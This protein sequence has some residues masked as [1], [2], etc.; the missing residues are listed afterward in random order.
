MIKSIISSSLASILLMSSGLVFS[1]DR[2]L[3]HTH[4]QHQKM[5]KVTSVQPIY[6]HHRHHS[7]HATF[8]RDKRI[9]SL[10]NT[11]AGGMIGGVAG[12]QFGNTVITI[13]TVN[14]AK[15]HHYKS[16]KASSN[17][18]NQ[19][20]HKPIAYDVTYR[21]GGQYYQTKMAQK[22]GRYIPVNV[23]V[24]PAKRHYR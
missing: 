18:H 22:P 1:G 6:D 17:K 13:T 15:S 16:R 3:H 23:H 12:H 9:H 8:S 2:M 10:T 14:T 11:V 21:Y 4:K 19:R 20:H 5:A 24:T 7:K